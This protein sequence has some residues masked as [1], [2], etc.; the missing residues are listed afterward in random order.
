MITVKILRVKNIMQICGAKQDLKVLSK[1]NSFIDRAGTCLILSLQH[2]TL[3][4]I[5]LTAINANIGYQIIDVKPTAAPM[6]KVKP[7]QKPFVRRKQQQQQQQVEKH[8]KKKSVPLPI[9]SIKSPRQ[10]TATA[11]AA[12]A[13]ATSLVLPL[14]PRFIDCAL[15][16]E[17]FAKIRNLFNIRDTVLPSN[18]NDY[19]DF[20]QRY[21]LPKR[22]G[23]LK[24]LG[25]GLYGT[26]LL[27]KRLPLPTA[28]TVDPFNTASRFAWKLS[29]LQG[30]VD[31]PKYVFKHWTA[32]YTVRR[33]RYI[34]FL[35]SSAGVPVPKL[36]NYSAED[37]LRDKGPY[38]FN[39]PMA[40]QR[41]LQ[42]ALQTSN[43]FVVIN[44]IL[45]E[46]IEMEPID[47]LLSGWLANE[48]HTQW[49]LDGLL[50]SIFELTEQISAKN[51]IHRDLH[52]LNLAWKGQVRHSSSGRSAFLGIL[53]AI[54][55]GLAILGNKNKWMD[56]L[57]LLSNL[58]QRLDSI[59]NNFKILPNRLEYG[60]A[61]TPIVPGSEN[62]EEE[63][64]HRA[65]VLETN[66][67]NW[68]N[69]SYLV[70]KFWSKLDNLNPLLKHAIVKQFPSSGELMAQTVAFIR[71]WRRRNT[72][73]SKQDQL[74][75]I[76]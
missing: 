28:T 62:E 16:T 21:F 44:G 71:E 58:E 34:Q 6:Q 73:S 13:K 51:V 60:I 10:G 14:A 7:K 37:A 75:N 42:H 2:A 3:R 55:F 29:L 27:M 76:D 36:I 57:I 74:W 66:F 54:D 15:T 19:C 5:L 17:S 38:S 30:S 46:S 47:G 59:E 41:D 20:L 64:L 68:K 40:A 22:Y 52:S 70:P 49:R 45:F 63:R 26:V 11:T 50:N 35:L 31:D 23:I 39:E 33:E 9:A 8:K 48:V 43:E 72:I 32:I 4:E 65:N 12:G 61:K 69:L 18:S 53:Y 67:H 56:R 1:W 24:L 25:A